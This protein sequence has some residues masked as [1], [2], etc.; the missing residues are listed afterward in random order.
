MA[1]VPKEGGC[2]CGAI[3]YT[4]TGEPVSVSICHCATC[5]KS[6]GAPSVAWAV[7]NR[8][9]FK[10]IKGEMAVYASSPNVQRGHCGTCGTSLTFFEVGEDTIDVTV[11]SLD[12]PEHLSPTKEIWLS[13]RLSWE[14]VSPERACFNEGS[15]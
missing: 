1:R 12:D 8:D 9:N 3:R 6:A 2:L 10:I 13:H 11:A 15:G 7:C 5:R 14:G 4:V